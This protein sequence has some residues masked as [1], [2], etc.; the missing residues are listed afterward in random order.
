MKMIKD[1]EGQRTDLKIGNDTFEKRVETF[2]YLDMILTEEKEMTQ[3]IK[4]LGYK[5]V[6][7]L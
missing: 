6:I 4:V 1:K 5:V 2:K 3:E 7:E